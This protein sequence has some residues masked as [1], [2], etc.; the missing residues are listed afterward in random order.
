MIEV[1]PVS[2]GDVRSYGGQVEFAVLGPLQVLGPGGPVD[3]VGA[4]ERA[5]L[6]HLVASAGRMVST[7]ELIDNLWGDEPPRTATKSL[8]NYV[9]RLRNTLEPDR[10]GQ[11]RVLVTDGRGYR[12]VVPEQA[13]DAR[14]FVRLVDLGRQALADGRLDAAALTL[15][16]ALA[17]WRGPAYAGLESARVCG[18][19]ARRLEELRIAAVED[20]ITADLDRGQAREAVPELESLVHE[21]P[22]R[23]RLWHLLVLA[24][25]RSG[26]QADALGAYGRARE[27]LLTELG[28]DP[29]EELR[30]L[31]AQVLS[32]DSALR[33]P[34]LAP[35][36]PRSL[37]PPPG[38]FVGRDREL[39]LLGDAWDRA[40]HGA[41]LTVAL[42]GPPGSGARR[43]AAEFA[44]VVAGEGFPV[45][46]LCAPAGT[47][48]ITDVPTLTVVDGAAAG[49]DAEGRPDDGA[50]P[51]QRTGPR[52]VVLVHAQAGAVPPGAQRLDL[53][54][55]GA[56]EVRAVLDSYLPSAVDEKTL[57]RVRRESGGVAG[58]VHDAALALARRRT[59][60]RVS[61]AVVRTTRMQSSL[62]VARESL[63]DGVAEFGGNLDRSRPV[64]A[65]VCPWKGLVSYE[66]ADAPWF[67]GRERLVAELMARIAPSPLLAVVGASGSGK[68]S[69]VRAGLLAS[70]AA[71]ALPG[72][73][74]WLQLVMR[75]GRHP[76]RELVR[77]TLR[78]R[79]RTRDDVADM[80][81][82]LVYGGGAD[83]GV[84]LVVDQLEEAWTACPDPVER[85]AFLDALSEIVESE[86][87]SEP[88]S[89][90]ESGSRC[91]VVLAV[92]ADYV[93][94]L[95]DHPALARAMADATVLVGAPSEAEVRRTV[96]HPA[97][98]SGLDLD[99]GLT[100]ALVADAGAEPGVLP[101]L[102]TALAELWER[103]DGDRLTLAAYVG[104]G[105]LRGAVARIA[106]R[107]YGALD[108]A[109]QAAA[110]VLLLRLAGPGEADAATRRRVPLAEL[111]ALPD[112]R[113]GAVVDPLTD[114]RLLSLGADH[115][116]VAHEALFREWP[117][118]RGWL[119]EDAEAR[120]VQRRLVVAAAEWDAGG[121]EAAQLWRGTRLVAGAD[122][123]TAHPR[124]VTDVERSFVEEGQAQ[125][126]AEQ[127]AVQERA[128]AATRQNRR[129]RFLL[130]GL[131][132]LLILALVAGTLAVQARSRAEREATV[133]QARALAAGSVA[134][135]T[136]DAELAVLLAMEAVERARTVGGQALREG[137]EA[138]HQA[139]ASSRIVSVVDGAGGAL[140][141]SP[142]G[143]TYAT[144]APE[145]NGAVE[146]RDAASGTTT[147]S[148]AGHPPDLVDLAFSADGSMLATTGV[149]GALKLWDPGTGQL[150]RTLQGAPE[151][152]VVGPSF[153]PDG[154]LVAASWQGE[155]LARVWDRT[156][157]AVG[158]ELVT[159]TD[160]GLPSNTTAFSPDGTRFAFTYNATPRVVELST[161]TAIFD[162][163]GNT[164]PVNDIEW[165][166][167]GRY[168]ATV[169]NDYHVVVWDGA[170]GA[171]LA[172]ARGHTSLIGVT[173]WSPDSRRLA[174]G[175]RDGSAKVWSVGA[176]RD[177]EEVMSLSAASTQPGVGWMAFS[178][179]GERLLTGSFDPPSATTWDVGVTGGAEVATYPVDTEGYA[180]LDYTADGDR[181]V[182]GTGAG[183]A[184]V[185]D[186]ATGTVVQRMGPHAGM[187]A[188][189]I[190]TT[191]SVDVS[192]DGSL[193]ATTGADE[194]MSV[195]DARTGAEVFTRGVDAVGADAD[196]GGEVVVLDRAGQLLATRTTVV[197]EFLTDVEFS[198]AGQLL[199]FASAPYVG[200]RETP[201]DVEVWDW[202][203]DEVVL[204][205]PL[206][207]GEPA[208]SFHPDGDRIVVAQGEKATVV[209]VPSGAELTV[210]IGHSAANVAVAYSPDGSRI[211]TG[212]EDGAVRVWDAE[213]GQ[214]VTVL[215]GQATRI[216][217]VVFSPDST[218]LAA[219]DSEATVRV[220]ALDLDDLIEIARARV[221]R[222]FTGDECR[223]YLQLE[224]C[225]GTSG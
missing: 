132:A 138:L 101:L 46:Y 36:L 181:L 76:L 74:R 33:A 193:I 34:V 87:E 117:R 114:A 169:G 158:H 214:P 51:A 225:P 9:L 65:D 83:G 110:R 143:T 122:F 154:Q 44:E 182:V 171:E 97:A 13:V 141:W 183:E 224:A 200:Y 104:A 71:G 98:R 190:R 1:K 148:W 192:P 30:R 108:A 100:D 210:M 155:G 12:L 161:G 128:A 19:E 178:P 157:G 73:D 124:E 163:P 145:G 28:V 25:Y 31:H 14:R 62:S 168:I 95:A 86:P 170:T 11:P 4:K 15:A 204:R 215:R 223:L 135:V 186:T 49:T 5:L 164:F 203:R 209:G 59:H 176:E 201:L 129:L 41:C 99:T 89:K 140:D 18:G 222:G 123:A 109:D 48:P 3:I 67:A 24:L 84:V 90:S 179:D 27:V 180:G 151:T 16:E 106:E 218:R 156:T 212:H 120:A 121:R 221:T 38:P 127:R 23:E 29:G 68:S 37:R 40:R 35:R 42:C 207:G 2:S 45:E 43:L 103:R 21:H 220:S 185:R 206:A 81:E 177:V 60:E 57:E 119:A 162:L 47:F 131:A 188:D 139:V 79:Q 64:Q 80:L 149:D 133:A 6:A 174:T 66:V 58:R 116:E 118:L 54:P 147:V 8:Q 92:R 107:A 20:R 134:T 219:S 105:G 72:S 153:S 32:Q 165:S 197:G 144:E 205:I 53:T 130:G 202:Q 93:G 94:E 112:P 184:T 173:T 22:L 195:W 61:D 216:K 115:V 77:V 211:A 160:D 50:V 198:P 82:Q 52:L 126:D 194:T 78:G 63:K 102:S 213:S 172:R 142:D 96:E 191:Y 55:L 69:L 88:K 10:D 111:A 56:P 187:P 150:L 166:P 17:L 159:R 152:V 137:E 189:T 125:Q 199:A 208:L 91:K 217:T 85:R 39:D 175:S 113:V 146:I 75:P 196:S 7:E 167:D 26:R 136:Q 70:L